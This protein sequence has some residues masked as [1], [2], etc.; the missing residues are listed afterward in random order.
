MMSFFA[1][2]DKFEL[3]LAITGMACFL[4]LVLYSLYVAFNKPHPEEKKLYL[5]PMAYR[6]EHKSK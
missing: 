5:H 2:L 1:R 4:T 6:G 3:I